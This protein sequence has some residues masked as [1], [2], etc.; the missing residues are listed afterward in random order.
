MKPANRNSR[1]Q[2]QDINVYVLPQMRGGRIDY[3]LVVIDMPGFGCESS[4]V[5]ADRATIDLLTQLLSDDVTFGI[6]QLTCIGIVI[7]SSDNRLNHYAR[8][9]YDQ[10]CA[11]RASVL[12]RR[13]CPRSAPT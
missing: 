10:V 3:D 8:C 2:T 7:K 1:S 4:S 5:E 11:I 12:C 6:D 9:I 13:F